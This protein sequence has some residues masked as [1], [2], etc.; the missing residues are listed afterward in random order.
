[1]TV[2]KKPAYPVAME[3]LRNEKK[4]CRHPNKA[5]EISQ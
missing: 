4:I 2:D 1:V 3:E 5:S